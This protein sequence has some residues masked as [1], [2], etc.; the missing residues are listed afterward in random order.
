MKRFQKCYLLPKKGFEYAKVIIFLEV[1]ALVN[2]PILPIT[3]QY[4]ASKFTK[5]PDWLHGQSY[6]AK[7]K[8]D[9]KNP[10]MMHPIQIKPLNK[11]KFSFF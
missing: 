4:V 8:I 3:G 1:Q 10:K 2:R 5:G 6:T 7:S 9:E 11:Q